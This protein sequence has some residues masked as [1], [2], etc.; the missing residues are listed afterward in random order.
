MASLQQTLINARLKLAWGA[1]AREDFYRLMS[2]FI[3]DEVPVFQALEEIAKRWRVTKD[4]KAQI[5][6]AILLDMRGRSG[7]AMRLGQALR[8][9]AP[10]ME[11]IAIDAG[12]QAGAI[13]HGLIMAANLTKVKNEIN[14]TI[15]GK[16]AYPGILFLLFCGLLL[17]LNSFVMPV[18]SDI[19]PREL[20][21]A[22]PRLLGRVA[23]SVGL[24]VGTILG[25]FSTIGIAYT[26][27][28]GLWV[29]AARDW[30][31]RKI[32]PWTLN[33]QISSA[34]MMTCFAALLRSGTPLS[35]II[36]KMSSSA[37]EW[38]KYH[39][40]QIRSRMRHGMG[41][42]DAMSIDLFDDELRWKLG[43][44]GKLKSFSRALESLSDRQIR[45]LIKRVEGVMALVQTLSMMAIAAMVV[46]VYTSF[47]AITLAARQA[48]TG[49]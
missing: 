48:Q 43:V 37:S 36:S 47:M 27:S 21:P 11:T 13:G 26:F 39:L 19:L 35:E 49:L 42:G 6:D 15:K 2:D 7:E 40:F 45:L 22:G 4:P 23:D 18:F 3:Q 1:Q 33:R 38:E 16:L 31:D 17:G 44:Y 30:F 41:E 46:W 29:G 14:S 5:M 12:E 24:I 8:Q 10:S 34:I 28:R 32:F 25:S 9:W 20:W